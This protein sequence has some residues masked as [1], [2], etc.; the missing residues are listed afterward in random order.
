MTFSDF[1]KMLYPF[2]GDGKYQ[3]DFV[4]ALISNITEDTD[5]EQCP[6][7]DNKP[8]YLTRIFNGSKP[9][10]RK[11][12]TFMVGHMDKAKFEVY[13]SDLSDD[14]IEGLRAALADKGITVSK[15]YQVA[16]KCADVFAQILTDCA[17]GSKAAAPDVN[18]K[19]A[20]ELVPQLD[21]VQL[22]QVPLAT[23]YVKDGKIHI[24]G[25]VIKLPAKLLP[26]VKIEPH[27]QVYVIELIAAYCD[28]ET[29]GG[30]TRENICKYPRYQRNFEEQRR[31]Y[32]NAESIR[33]SVREVF[34]EEGSD[35]F[36]ILKEDM[37]D[38]VSTTCDQDFDHGYARLIEVLKQ[39]VVVPV[40]KS[41]LSNIPNWIGNSE[42][43]GVC[44]M[45]VNDGKIRWVLL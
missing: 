42:K 5:D 2:C 31:N 45:L 20:D 16:A 38:G 41:L 44:H 9:L 40:G 3:S 8:D 18:M 4:V 33:R 24:G 30:V 12:A 26:P 22:P 37:Y 39:A 29:A 27:E 10:P 19:I 6:L 21:K 32:Y 14:A 7:L 25:N 43:K 23:V 17:S 28:A 11:D 35:Q 15:K 13:I 36:E 34:A 1:A